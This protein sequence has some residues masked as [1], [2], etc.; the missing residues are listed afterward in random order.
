LKRC[1]VPRDYRD[2]YRRRV[3]RALAR[4]L[5]R[6]QGRGHPRSGET[7]LRPKPKSSDERLE[8]ALKS[9]RATGNQAKAA[10][11]AG[12]SPERFRRFLRENKLA[13]R[14]GRSWRITDDR[15]RD[16]VAIT[17]RGEQRFKIAGFEV[18]SLVMSHRAAVIRFRDTNES[19]ELER[20]VGVSVTDTR[21]RKHTLETHPNALY[22]LAAAGSEGFEIVYRLTA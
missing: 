4:G 12:V 14:E 18:A 9:L 3:G 20:F 11:E 22:R 5:S 7:L 1:A 15:P 10:N 13:H 19:S 6:S 17:T 16:V 21:G 2:E 8:R